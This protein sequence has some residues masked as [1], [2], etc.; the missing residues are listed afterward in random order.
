MELSEHNIFSAIHLSDE[1][2]IVNILSGNADILN[3]SEAKRFLAKEVIADQAY[4]DKGYI[5]ER[6]EEDKQFRLKY[7]DFLD[8]RENDEIQL[9]YVPSY[10]CNFNCSY[11]YQDG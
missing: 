8:A 11:C 1:Y 10:A 2:F 6:K 9:F 7:L 3:P 4:I 5:V